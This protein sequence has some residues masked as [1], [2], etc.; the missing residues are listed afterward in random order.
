MV[1]SI[2]V[3]SKLLIGEET[4]EYCN[5]IAQIS[6]IDHPNQRQLMLLPRNLHDRKIY[7]L[8]D[9]W[10]SSIH[11]LYKLPHSII[12]DEIILL[13]SYIRA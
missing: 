10:S 11:L 13:F 6:R 5:H 4:L 1:P 12:D 7:I 2:K 9:E 3:V 8:H